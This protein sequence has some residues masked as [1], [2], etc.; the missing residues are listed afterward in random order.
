MAA[1]AT[2]FVG[3]LSERLFGFS[4]A[5][6]VSGDVAVDRANAIALGNALLS[7]LVVPWSLC[8]LAYSFLHMT[9]PRDKRQAAY[10]T[11]AL[12]QNGSF[13]STLSNNGDDEMDVELEHRRGLTDIDRW[14]KNQS[15]FK[16]NKKP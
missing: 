14:N 8:L 6:T 10:L 2:P 5:S 13:D 12:P 7:F 11:R 1:F 9:Y 15:G 4:G 16:Q 3:L